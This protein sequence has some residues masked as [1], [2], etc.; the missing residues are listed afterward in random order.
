MRVSRLGAVMATA[1]AILTLGLGACSS[2]KK[3]SGTTTT[4]SSGSSATTT[5][6]SGAPSSANVTSIDIHNFMFQPNPV[7]VKAG[8][9]ITVTNQDGTDHSLTADNASFDTG[10]FSSG[11]KTITITKAGTYTIHCRIHNFMTGTIVA[12]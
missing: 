7:H 3:A 10:V 9:A 2:S 11:S 5:G 8:Q 12:S 6:T 1:A 4:T